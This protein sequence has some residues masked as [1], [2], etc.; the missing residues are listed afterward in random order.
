MKLFSKSIRYALIIL[1]KPERPLSVSVW[2]LMAIAAEARYRAEG[3][4]RVLKSTL[5]KISL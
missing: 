5:N 4:F 1:T 3:Q 2:R